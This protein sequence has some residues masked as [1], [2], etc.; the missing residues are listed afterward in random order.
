[1]YLIII[2]NVFKVCIV[3][4]NNEPQ[5]HL[6]SGVDEAIIGKQYYNIDHGNKY[7]WNIFVLQIKPSKTH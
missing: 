4:S 6:A 3:S 2:K 1:M 5:Y 7:Q